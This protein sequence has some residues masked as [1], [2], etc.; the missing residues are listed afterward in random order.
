MEI[1]LNKYT[2]KSLEFIYS[3]AEKLFSETTASFRVITNYSYIATGVYFSVM[4]FCFSELLK[5]NEGGSSPI[6]ISL[7]IMMI[8]PTVVLSPN[9]FPAKISLPGAKPKNLI[10][11]WYEQSTELQQKLYLQQRITDINNAID[12]NGEL[13][14]KRSAKLRWSIALAFASLV[15]CLCLWLAGLT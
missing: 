10:H 1:D 14:T 2:E 12:S 15:V 13:L 3:E 6:L 7:M 4:S 5:L 8:V 9:L 11:E